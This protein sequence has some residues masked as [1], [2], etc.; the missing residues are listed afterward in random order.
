M[1]LLLVQT[2]GDEFAIPARQV[3]E[4]L[5]RIDLR[6]VPHAPAFFAGL[7]NYRGDVV[8]VVDLSTLMGFER[9]RDALS[10]R[11]I[12]TRVGNEKNGNRS[13]GLIAER[14]IHLEEVDDSRKG[15]YSPR[16]ELAPY[17]GSVYQLERGLVQIIEVDRVLDD[18]VKSMLFGET[19]E[20]ANP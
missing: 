9:S 19:A 20:Q 12:L 13:I 2:A 7:L 11:I 4:V 17:L 16:H 10:T 1:L 6:A 3:V 5:P 14:V 15:S 8:P 18:R